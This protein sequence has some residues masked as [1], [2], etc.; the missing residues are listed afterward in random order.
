MTWGRCLTTV[1]SSKF[2][3]FSGF[4]NH[5]N[6]QMSHSFKHILLAKMAFQVILIKVDRRK[7]KE[8]ILWGVKKPYYV[9]SSGRL[10]WSVLLLLQ[11]ISEDV[12]N[13]GVGLYRS[14]LF[15]N[16]NP[17]GKYFLSLISQH[18]K[19]K[20]INC[21]CFSK[22]I[23]TIGSFAL[24]NHAQV[25]NSVELQCVTCHSPCSFLNSYHLDFT[26]FRFSLD[27]LFFTTCL[28]WGTDN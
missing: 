6:I 10:W 24:K 9:H 28:H 18:K 2:L 15:A 3:I 5:K 27:F 23:N 12:L 26:C 16:W 4:P 7:T 20:R 25:T 11:N 13:F 19:G 14:I 8:N 22:C 21:Y 17:K 1:Y